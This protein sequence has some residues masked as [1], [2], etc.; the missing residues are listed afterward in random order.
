VSEYYRG[1][2]ILITG[3][4]GF[5]GSN[6]ALR[7]TEL[8]AQV[9]LVD[10][11][12]PAYG[13]TLRNIEP[14]EGQVRV[15]FSDV[16][17]QHGLSYIVQGQE[18]IFSLAGQV[19]HRESMSDPMT[20]LDI[21]CRSQLSLLECCRHGNPGVKIVFASTRQIYGRPQY[22]PVDEQHPLVPVDING[23]NKL[24]AEMYYGLYHSVHGIETVSLRLTNTYGPRMDLEN[25]KKGFVGVFVRKAMR[26]E[27]IQVYGTGQQR[28]DF[29]YVDDVV[30]ALLL[31]GERDAAQGEVF[32]LGHPEPASLLEFVSTL[33]KFADFDY[34]IAPFPASA[35]A[36]DIGDYFG[37]F[38]K[39]HEATGWTPRV[40]LEAGLEKTIGYFRELSAPAR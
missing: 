21:N 40:D 28:R 6:L 16:R 14:I 32:N 9:V 35:E 33:Q 13:A 36:I 5:I 1:K 4:L 17:D 18:L 24:A 11:M 37:D 26:G 10:S 20:D 23:I 8:G 12:L 22:L 34:E 30:D 39:F 25:D 31:A 27:K 2:R 3:G 38:S 15:N 7:L 29:N 19:S